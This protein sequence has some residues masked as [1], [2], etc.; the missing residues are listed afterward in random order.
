MRIFITGATSSVA[1]KIIETLYADGNKLTLIVSY[2]RGIK[3]LRKIAPKS[4]ILIG[5]VY[6]RKFIGKALKN[7]DAVVHTAIAHDT[8]SSE[9][10]VWRVNIE[11]TFVV[12]S[13]AAK[14]GVKKFI[15]LSS[16]A[17]IDGCH[18]FPD[19]REEEVINPK[20]KQYHGFS[21]YLGELITKF[22]AEHYNIPSVVLRLTIVAP[23][24]EK[25]QKRLKESDFKYLTSAK[26]VSQAVKLALIKDLPLNYEVFHIIGN[27]PQRS[28]MNQKAKKL[29]GYKP[30]DWYNKL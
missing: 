6:D 18:D 3:D 15:F 4:N 10:N 23:E 21:K 24:H 8:K 1:K 17:V 11:G 19:I 30:K 22:Y 14:F 26:D 2:K 12:A 20:Q 28:W 7:H 27:H 25:L 16:F 9:E 5:K 13:E 29:L